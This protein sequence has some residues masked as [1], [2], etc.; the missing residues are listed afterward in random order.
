VSSREYP[1]HA[2]AAVAAVVLKD[3]KLL[4]IRRAHPPGEGLWA[5]PGGVIE[6][7]ERV[8][9]AAKRELA[10][11][12]GLTGEPDGILGLTQVIRRDESG[13]VRWHYLIVLVSFNPETLRGVLKPS[14]DAADAMWLPL[15]ELLSRNDVA[16]TTRAV[17]ELLARSGSR[18]SL[19]HVIG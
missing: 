2:V 19:S 10:E 3:R 8:L 12:T 5:I 13:A 18:L 11:E 4:V 7:G 16:V 1:A 15:E 14:G 9:D 17:A 6:A